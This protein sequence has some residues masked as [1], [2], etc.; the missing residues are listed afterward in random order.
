[1][2]DEL[3]KRYPII[4]DQVDERELRVI[5]REL[6]RVLRG[7]VPGAIVEFGCYEG[8]TSLF[9]TRLLQKLGADRPFHA[10]D[11]FSGLPAKT[12]PD[13]SRAGEQFQAGELAA[14]K[15]RFMKNFKQ[16][17]L[18]LPT[19]HKSWFRDL[20]SNDVPQ[21]IA[22][23]FLDG[24]FYESIFD[25][26]KLLEDKLSAGAIIVVDDY[27]SEALP[28]AAKAVNRWL[29]GKPHSLRNEASLAI[30]HL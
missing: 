20:R 17:N 26:L 10:Y 28:G 25:S 4:S 23:A 8:T 14:S 3:L 7:G 6:E 19:I 12:N 21:P 2:P 13:F 16:A 18:P 30:I 27:Q 5:L 15:Q 22:F 9:I 1:M 24:D 11:S 29:K